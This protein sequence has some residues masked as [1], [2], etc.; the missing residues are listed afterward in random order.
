MPCEKNKKEART[1]YDALRLFSALTHGI[2]FWMASAGAGVLIAMA[3]FVG[4]V[5]HVVS[6]SVYGAALI[7]LY[8][9]STLYHSLRVRPERRKAL[10]KADHIMI[11]MLIAGTYTP[12]CLVLLREESPGW[13]WAIFGVIWFFAIAGTIVKLCW[14]NAPRWVS[15]AAYVAMGWIVIIAIV[16]LINALRAQEQMRAFVWLMIGGGFYT[17]GGILYALRWPGRDRKLFGFHEVFHIFIL[18]GSISHF[19]MMI[20]CVK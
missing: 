3:A 9:A 19:A 12:I 5:W 1:P 7:G 2:G 4:N 15:A 13:G 8:A 16:P 10:R 11:Y 14:L 17:I 6:Y 18:L 20:A